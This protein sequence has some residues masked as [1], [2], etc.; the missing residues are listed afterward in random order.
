MTPKQEMFVLEYLKDLNTSQAMI[1]AGY[2]PRT[3]GQMGFKLLKN[4][5]VQAAIASAMAARTDRVKIDVD[6]VVRELQTIALADPRDLTE[7]RRLCCRYCHGAGFRYQRTAGEM[8]V[9]L[10]KWEALPA[11]RRAGKSFDEKGGTG[12]HGKREPHK[13]CPEC[14]GD[15]VGNVFINDTRRLSTS[16]AKLFAGVKRTKDGIEVMMRD[17]DSATINLGRH[18]GAFKDRLE[19]KDMTDRAAALDRA[20]KRAAA[21]RG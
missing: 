14:F 10:E 16:A 8:E 19:V 1:R 5:Q 11:K 18:V 9:D 15:G 13:D 7:Y 4:A 17:Q 12:F 3:A 21:A 20:R 2:A 6:A